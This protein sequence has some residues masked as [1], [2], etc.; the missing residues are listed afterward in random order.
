[1]PSRR[2]P[3]S[4]PRRYKALKDAQLKYNTTA[5][6][7]RAF[8][9]ATFTTLNSTIT[10]FEGASGL[11]D[12]DLAQQ[13]SATTAEDAAEHFLFLNISH[14][15]QVF[16]F[17][18]LRNVFAASDRAYFGLDA[19]SEHLPTLSSE[20]D[21]ILWATRIAD[22]DVARVAAGGAAMAMPSAAQVGA[23]FTSFTNLRTAQSTKT[24]AR[25][26]DDIALRAMRPAVDA[27]ITDIWDQTE[28]FYR[29]NPKPTLRALATEWGVVYI[30]NAAPPPPP[31][32]PVG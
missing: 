30:T 18:V 31:T 29:H 19:N 16:N 4:D 25:I 17:G 23:A 8:D 28:F 11:S 12:A 6:P 26:T 1:M 7:Q 32:P 20:D 27:L 2:L 9:A 10:A 13:I 24:G 15:F 14:F 22:G 21:L 3:S 5:A